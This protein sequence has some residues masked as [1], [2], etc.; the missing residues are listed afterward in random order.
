MLRHVYTRQI[1]PRLQAFRSGPAQTPPPITRLA[2]HNLNWSTWGY[3]QKCLTPQPHT[4]HASAINYVFTVTW[5]PWEHCV[6]LPCDFFVDFFVNFISKL[7][8][9]RLLMISSSGELNRNKKK[10]LPMVLDSISAM[11]PF[12]RPPNL[13]PAAGR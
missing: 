1:T 7:F 10:G 2:L 9:Q 12:I 6:S 13:P 11:Q 3:L 4:E 5:K 8:F